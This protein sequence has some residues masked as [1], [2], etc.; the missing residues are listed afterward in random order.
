MWSPVWKGQTE[1]AHAQRGIQI[2]PYP[3]KEKKEGN[4]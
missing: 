4:R 2:E 1:V 3:I